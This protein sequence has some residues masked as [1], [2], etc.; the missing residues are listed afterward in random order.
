MS[1]LLK[2]QPQT[3]FAPGTH[4]YV[5]IEAEDEG[6]R[7]YF[8]RSDSLEYHRDIFKKFIKGIEKHKGVKVL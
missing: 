6:G 7:V 4:K 2:I 3:Q 5:L 1:V 8:V